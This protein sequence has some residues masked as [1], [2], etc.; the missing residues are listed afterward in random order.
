VTWY[1]KFLNHGKIKCWF[2]FRVVIYLS[3][4]SH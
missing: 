2:D 1:F 3:G 4:R